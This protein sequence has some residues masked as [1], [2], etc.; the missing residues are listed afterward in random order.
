MH[1][2]ITIPARLNS[3]DDIVGT[4]T[5]ASIFLSSFRWPV[6]DVCPVCEVAGF[7]H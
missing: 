4:Y 5:V 7:S 2:E 1:W 6:S 3:T